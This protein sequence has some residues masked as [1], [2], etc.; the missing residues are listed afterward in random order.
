MPP[1]LLEIL[2]WEPLETEA[3]CPQCTAERSGCV[4]SA[5]ALCECV[6]VPERAVVK[7]LDLRGHLDL[8]PVTAHKELSAVWPFMWIADQGSD[9]WALLKQYGL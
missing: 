4:I 9:F 1:V 7:S 5:D 3:L 6:S 8:F 2:T